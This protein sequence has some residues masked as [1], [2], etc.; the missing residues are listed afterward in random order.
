[1]GILNHN[2]NENASAN[3][4]YIQFQKDLKENAY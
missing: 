4:G 2:T 1:M 3:Q